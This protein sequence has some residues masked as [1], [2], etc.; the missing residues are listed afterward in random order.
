MLPPAITRIPLA[1][2]QNGGVPVLVGID[3][4][5]VLT[6]VAIDTVRNRR[7]HPAFAWGGLL[8]IGGDALVLMFSKTSAWMH[9]GYW[10]VR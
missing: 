7:L 4:L 1:L 8:F 9:I 2:I 6:V 10:L 5:F 3:Y